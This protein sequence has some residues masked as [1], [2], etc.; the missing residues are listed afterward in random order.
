MGDQ[1]I[2]RYNPAYN[3]L[4]TLKTECQQKDAPDYVLEGINKALELIEVSLSFSLSPFAAVI[5]SVV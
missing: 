1:T 5:H 4:V 3:Q 2:G